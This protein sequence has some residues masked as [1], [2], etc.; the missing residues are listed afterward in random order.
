M[1]FSILV[2]GAASL[3]RLFF[4]GDLGRGTAYLTYY[5][6]VMIVALH[7]G[8]YAGLVGMIISALLCFYW[9]QHGYMSQIETMAFIVF[10]ISCL[11][12]SFIAEAMKRARRRARESQLEAEAANKAKTVFLA[13]MSHELRTPLNAVLGYSQLMQRDP[14]LGPDLREYIRIINRSGEHLLSL[15]N[16]I[17]EIAKIEAGHA[18]LEPVTFGLRLMIEEV[19]EM[20]SEKINSKGLYFTILGIETLPRFVAADATKLRVILINLLGNAVKFT[21]QGGIT[22]RFSVKTQPDGELLLRVEVEDT[23]AGISSEEMPNLFTYFA[24]TDSGRESRSGTG[25]G[26][27]ISRDYVKM[28]GGEIS[29]TS[30]LGKGSTFC[31]TIRISAEKDDYLEPLYFTR[32]V[33]SLVPGTKIPRVLIAEDT[34][35]NRVLLVRLLRDVGIEVREASNGQEAVDVFEAWHPDFIWMDIRMPVMDGMEATRRIKATDRGK[36]TKI[37]AL[38]A[39]VLRKEREEIIAAG[40]E[41]F[42]EKPFREEKIFDV[43]AKQLG[44]HYLFTDNQPVG[45]PSHNSAIDAFDLSRLETGFLEELLSAVN[46]TDAMKISMLAKQLFVTDP[47]IASALLSCANNFDYGSIQS[48]LRRTLDLKQ[49]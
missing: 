32:R 30:R 46:N 19:T 21:Q 41:D 42:V 13:N 31:F 16:D 25:L 6:A 34:E 9:I 36:S 4:F 45:H 26:L 15:I 35:V 5:P 1:L 39:H 37:V 20:F 22:V 14:A 10:L 7:G 49:E 40:C 3:I 17:L 18:V 48:A 33:K 8:L 27:A 47:G 11:M 24:Q 23:G 28:M 44:L 12:I 2:I 38:S 29:A 43:M